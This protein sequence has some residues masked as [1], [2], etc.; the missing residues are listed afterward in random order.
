[1]SGSND[2]ACRIASADLSRYDGR[3]RGHLRGSFSFLQHGKSFQTTVHS[4]ERVR[5]ES[6]AENVFE[7]DQQQ[8]IRGIQNHSHEE[9]PFLT[10]AGEVPE[11]HEDAGD[12]AIDNQVQHNPR[13][14]D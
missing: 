5:M 7:K 9:R 11:E 3:S 12:D 6:Y 13:R 14:A 1:M 10:F 4:V 2:E 8:A